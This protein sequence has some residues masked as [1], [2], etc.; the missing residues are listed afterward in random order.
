MRSSLPTTVEI[1]QNISA[2]CG[3]VLADPTQIHQ[4]AMNLMT[5]AYQAMEEEGGKLEVTLKEVELGVYD[6]PDP[7]MTPGAYVCLTVADT[8][9][10]MDQSTIDRIFEPY[11]TTKEDGKGTGLGLA[12]VHG[13][14]KNFNGDIKIYSEPGKGTAFHVYYSAQIN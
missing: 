10:G 14:V 7:S 4:V 1:K 12:V 2:K 3:Y 11:F 8:G 6:L 5:N 13:I 9:I